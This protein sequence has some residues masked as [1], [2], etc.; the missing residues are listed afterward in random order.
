MCTRKPYALLFVEEEFI[1]WRK[2]N[3]T[4]RTEKRTNMLTYSFFYLNHYTHMIDNHTLS[5]W[6]EHNLNKDLFFE[7][8]KIQIKIKCIDTLFKGLLFN[9]FSFYRFMS[10]WRSAKCLLQFMNLAKRSPTFS[11]ICRSSNLRKR[12]FRSWE[13]T[14]GSKE[15]KKWKG[16]LI[17]CHCSV[18]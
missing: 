9:K 8:H 6:I 1:G 16:T 7:W 11:R 13:D 12:K 2:R 14:V 17:S 4:E 15:D 18:I 10:E 3:E 5:D